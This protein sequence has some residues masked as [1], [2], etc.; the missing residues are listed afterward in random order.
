VKTLIG[1]SLLF[2]SACSWFGAHRHPA[3]DSAELIVTGA[4]A[5]SSLI[6]DGVRVGEPAVGGNHSQVIDVPPGPHRVEIQVENKI[7][8]REETDAGIGEHRIVTVLSGAPR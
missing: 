7:V 5:G 6:V 3:P 8:Y 1:I 2:L 4:P